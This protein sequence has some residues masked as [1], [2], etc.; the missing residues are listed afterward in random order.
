MIGNISIYKH[1]TR[2]QLSRNSILWIFVDDTAKAWDT[3]SF[4]ITL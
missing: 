1:G 4:R 2:I 3:V